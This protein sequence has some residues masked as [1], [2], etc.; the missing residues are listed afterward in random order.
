MKRTST[1][2]AK[3]E[4]PELSREQLGSGVRGKYF[5]AYTR[6]SNVIVLKPELQ[7]IFPDSE[8][9]NNAL[10]SLVAFAKEAKSL[11]S[12]P[13]GKSAKRRSA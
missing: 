4:I 10:T 3:S 11:T 12:R 2:K 8:A 7:K 1:S 9:V 6:A 5:E 13:V